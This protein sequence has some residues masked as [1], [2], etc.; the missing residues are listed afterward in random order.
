MTSLLAHR[1]NLSG[2]DP[3]SE[4]ALPATQR[5]LELGFGLEAELRHDSHSSII[6]T[7]RVCHA[8]SSL[9]TAHHT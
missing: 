3:V 9:F 5:A 8:Y 6:H 1:A 4:N 7:P 2:A